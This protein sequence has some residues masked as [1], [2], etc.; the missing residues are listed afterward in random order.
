MRA[1]VAA[2]AFL[3]A[4]GLTVGCGGGPRYG[5]VSGTVTYDGKPVEQGSIT[6]LPADGRGPDAGGAIKDG[7]YTAKKVP[8]GAMKVVINGAKITGKKKMYDDPK[9]DWVVTSEEL[10]PKKYN[11]ATELKYDVQPGAQTKDFNLPK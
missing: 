5:E 4:V 7:Q 9:A 11:D 8:S 1:V 10:L 3:L 6:F 2:A